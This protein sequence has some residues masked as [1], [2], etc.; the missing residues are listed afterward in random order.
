MK[1][2]SDHPDDEC[3]LCL[4]AE[5]TTIPLT[6]HYLNEAAHLGDRAG[7]IN[8]GRLND[9]GAVGQIGGAAARVPRVRW[10][11]ASGR[12]RRESRKVVYGSLI[13]AYRRPVCRAR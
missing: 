9:I 3:D 13:S 2:G 1:C 4:K 8:D 11:E 7:I 5:G 6:T 10:R 12:R